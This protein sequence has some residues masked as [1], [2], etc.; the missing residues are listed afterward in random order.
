MVHL[1]VAPIPWLKTY[2]EPFVTHL[3]TLQD[4]GR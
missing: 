4:D 3:V 2:L 1:Q